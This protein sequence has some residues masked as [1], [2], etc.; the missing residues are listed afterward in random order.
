MPDAAA[1]VLQPLLLVGLLASVA[2]AF[3]AAVGAVSRANWLYWS[4]AG[5]LGLASVWLW[6]YAAGDDRY[7]GPSSVSR[8]EFA[9]RN[10]REPVVVVGAALA[11]V[12][13]VVLVLAATRG[14]DS[15]WKRTG[16]GLAALGIAGVLA[17]WVS[18]SAGH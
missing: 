12:A 8:W 6:G 2:L 4:F 16:I 18:L 7:Y 17:A 3:P 13:V 9:A 14:P 1:M 15:R 10:D 5:L 11:V